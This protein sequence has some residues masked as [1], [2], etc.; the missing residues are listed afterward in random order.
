MASFKGILTMT[1]SRIT[2]ILLGVSSAI[3]MVLLLE[4]ILR[5]FGYPAG[6]FDPIMPSSEG[7]YPP[8]TTLQMRWGP[9]PYTVKTNSL[10]L[11]GS[12][13]SL[14]KP[15]ETYRIVAVGDSITDGFFV[16]NE[17][18][19]ESYLGDQLRNRFSF[20]VDVI[21]CAH[22]GGSI[23]KE[24]DLL[25]R[26]GLTLE[27]DLVILT[28][29][30]NDIYE[31]VK[32]LAA[33]KDNAAP[34]NEWKPPFSIGAFLLTRTALGE[35]SLDG[36][37]RFR[38]ATYRQGR[39]HTTDDS[40]DQRYNIEGGDQ[41]EHNSDLFL[42]KYAKL[43]G[44]VLGKS[45]H[46]KVQQAIDYYSERLQQFTNLCEQQQV[47]LL[48]VYFPAYPQIYQPSPPR[49]INDT[50]RGL[51]ESATID[52]LDLTDGFRQRGAE[53]VLHLAP[54][55]FHPNPEGNRVFAELL[56][57]H[58]LP[59]LENHQPPPE[60]NLPATNPLSSG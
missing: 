29:V 27:P 25:E 43:D 36:L 16:D 55:D 10:G 57:Q 4:M 38:F 15:Q 49:L 9:I 24:I 26:I 35:A 42:T 30:T 8:N 56:T 3:A 46:R 22:G 7:H 51:C 1:M 54:L 48:F 23:D 52:F 58:L 21:N 47:A 2:S 19:W 14:P 5:L 17:A 41:F 32:L 18:T 11:R 12:E 59:V 60:D 45:F 33:R 34:S 40:T 50:L 13:I 44:L 31:I 28:F 6:T 20:P 53:R 39:G 37:L